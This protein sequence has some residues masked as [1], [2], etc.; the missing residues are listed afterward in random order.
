VAAY[1]CAHTHLVHRSQHQGTLYFHS[2]V[3]HIV[4]RSP[5]QSPSLTRRLTSDQAILAP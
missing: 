5:L 2:P 3:S 4:N 1:G